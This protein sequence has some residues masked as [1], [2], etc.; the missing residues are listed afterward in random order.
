[1]HCNNT[2]TPGRERRKRRGKGQANAQ[3]SFEAS[4]SAPVGFHYRCNNTS[5]CSY[6]GI[7]LSS[8][9]PLLVHEEF[10]SAFAWM[11]NLV[12][13]KAKLQEVGYDGDGD[14]VIEP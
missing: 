6:T 10:G 3:I 9:F 2:L 4:K 8:N 5:L 1:M 12:T 13:L 11:G 7:Y 14:M